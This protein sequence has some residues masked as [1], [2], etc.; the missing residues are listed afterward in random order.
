MPDI[1]RMINPPAILAHA[2]NRSNLKEKAS[3]TR[4][5]CQPAWLVTVYAQLKLAQVNC[6]AKAKA[7]TLFIEPKSMVCTLGIE[8]F[9]TALLYGVCSKAYSESGAFVYYPGFHIQWN[10]VYPEVSKQQ[11]K[12][13]FDGREPS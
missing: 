10:P 6:N 4:V 2:P 3:S 5:I 9:V 12:P 7:P 13:G 11:P 8:V 1:M